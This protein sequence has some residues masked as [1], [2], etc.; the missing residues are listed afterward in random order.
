MNGVFCISLWKSNDMTFYQKVASNIKTIAIVGMAMLVVYLYFRKDVQ[1]IKPPKPKWVIN[2]IHNKEKEVKTLEK[3][4][5]PDNAQIKAL[6]KT[7]DELM[8]DVAYLKQK[9]DTAILVETQDTLIQVLYYQGQVKDTV[10]RKQ[11]QII[12]DLKYI[13]ASKDTLLMISK[14][15]LKRSKRKNVILGIAA[16]LG[17]GVAVIKY[18]SSKI[19]GKNRSCS[20][21][22]V[23]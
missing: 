6:G 21:W 2:N 17:W 10:I 11:D 5:V 14:A 4:L 8:N 12:S 20:R 3:S 18:E 13:V 16:A 1:V 19:S 15:D 7:I 9:R 22:R 23:W